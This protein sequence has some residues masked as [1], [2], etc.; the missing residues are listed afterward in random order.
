MIF[1]YVVVGAGTA[2]C[3]LA[4]RLSADGRHRVLLL[5]AG[6]SDVHPWIQMPLGF[7][8]ALQQ[9]RFS[10]GYATDPEPTLKQRVLPVPRGRVLGGSSSIN[11]MFHIRGDRRDFDDWAAAGCSGWSYE[12]V[13]PYFIRSE[14][15]W[16][17]AG[18]HHGA[19]GPVQLRRIDDRRL[20]PE[21]LRE[22]ARA[23]GHRLNDDYDGEHHDGLAAGTVAID[24]RGRRHSSARAYLQPARGRSKLTV[25]TR[26]HA[27]GLLFEGQRATGVRV[28][29]AGQLITVQARREVILAGGTYGSPQLLMLSGI[30][31]AA[32]L[33][34]LGIAVV[35]DLP[36][37]GAN[38]TEHPRMP[39]QF[40]LKRP[41]SFLN[42]LRLDRALRSL[43]QWAMLGSGPFATQIC[44]GTL[45]LKTDGQRDRPD[46]QLLCNPVR[47]D[48]K[49]WFPLIAPVQAHAFYITVCQLYPKSRGK[50]SL[51]S[52][53]PAAPPRIHFNLFAHD[54]DFQTMRMALREARRL[55]AMPSLADLIDAE[56]L[57]GAN[58]QSDAQLDEAIRTLGGITHH[59]VGTCAMGVGAQAVV[60][61]RLRVHGISGLRVA[62]ASVM[63]S[64]VGGNT[65]AATLMIAEKAAE[66]ILQDAG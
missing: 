19:D 37:V 18:P 16:L 22:A 59:P 41:V 66:M 60:D 64:I 8:R 34:A 47:L 17:G 46:I 27:H 39:L 55:Y 15:H 14:S 29:R 43:L 48:A 44:H 11:G 57:P 24:S 1:D 54:E 3:V 10:W 61:P 63:P 33:Q 28:M 12:E 30:G 2:G 62:D 5:E 36:G 65:N 6:G 9:P 23:A 7:L 13:L 53:D 31:A 45:L 21:P 32:D 49:L 38:L 51:R 20:L 50:V 52:S 4:N 42:E 56:T 25:W 58:L 35:R 40:T 26:A